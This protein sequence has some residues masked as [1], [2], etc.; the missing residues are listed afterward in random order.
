MNVKHVHSNMTQTSKIGNTEHKQYNI[1][2]VKYPCND[3]IYW[4]HA[5]RITGFLKFLSQI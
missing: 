3:L 2:I 5:I 4:G 1:D